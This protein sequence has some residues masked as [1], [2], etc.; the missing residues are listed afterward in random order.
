MKKTLLTAFIVLGS[1]LIAT[2]QDSNP[3]HHLNPLSPKVFSGHGIPERSCEST[4]F[5]ALHFQRIDADLRNIAFDKENDDVTPLL[6]KSE[7]FFD[8]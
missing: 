2:A 8:T 5:S 6:P 4:G 3:A 7:P 1:A